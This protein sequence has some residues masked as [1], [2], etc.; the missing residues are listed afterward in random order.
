MSQKEK[1]F[2]AANVRIYTTRSEMGKAAAEHVAGLIREVLSKK[3]RANIVFAAAPSQNEF[4][5]HLTNSPGIDWPRVVGF[6]MDEYI[7]L[8]KESDQFFS[9]YLHN[10]LFSKVKIGSVQILDAHAKEPKKEC[11]RYAA[12]LKENPTDIVCLGIGENGHIAFNDPPVADFLDKYLVKIIEL[13]EADRRQQVNDGCFPTINDVPPT[14]FTLTIPALMSATY[15]SCVVPTERKA[16]AVFNS[17]TGKVTTKV[18]GSILRT[19][20]HIE[21]FLDEA[22]ASLL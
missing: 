16:R 15:L 6:H 13:D 8:P 4:L 5:F 19:H 11:H 17:L 3:E 10:H 2:G 14:A 9:L 18:P 7:G 22:S 1:K 21:L 20:P 12:L